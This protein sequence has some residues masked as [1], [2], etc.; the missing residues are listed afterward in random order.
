MLRSWGITLEQSEAHLTLWL[1][2]DAKLA[3]RQISNIPCRAEAIRQ[4][5][6][7]GSLEYRVWG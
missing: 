4:L 7:E 1:D 6:G 5:T 2:L 3:A